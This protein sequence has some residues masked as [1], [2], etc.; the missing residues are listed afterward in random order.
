MANSFVV[1][2]LKIAPL[3]FSIALKVADVGFYTRWVDM[4]NRNNGAKGCPDDASAHWKYLNISQ[5][6]YDESVVKSSLELS[7]IFL[8]LLHLL[9]IAQEGIQL[10]L[11]PATIFLFFGL[12]VE[13][14]VTTFYRTDPEGRYPNRYEKYYYDESSGIGEDDTDA[15][16]NRLLPLS[17]DRYLSP[18][19]ATIIVEL[20]IVLNV[21]ALETTVVLYPTQVNT[22]LP[23]ATPDVVATGSSII[24]AALVL[25]VT[26]LVFP[27]KRN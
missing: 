1:L 7:L 6:T 19:R 14:T 22:A 8:V 3:V 12:L 27:T 15:Y 21:I 5:Y 26:F 4:W 18:P 25:V 23:W 9:L 13:R 10:L 11:I 20:L 2:V 17:V 16:K 24:V